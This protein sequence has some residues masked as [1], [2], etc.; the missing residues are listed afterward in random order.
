M[1]E[2]DHSNELPDTTEGKMGLLRCELKNG[3]TTWLCKKHI[4]ATRARVIVADDTRII[5]T[6]TA[7]HIDISWLEQD[8]DVKIL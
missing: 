6:I 5:N 2:S 7:D 8:L 1:R 4:E 3:K